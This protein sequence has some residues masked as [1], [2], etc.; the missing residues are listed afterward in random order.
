[1]KTA[2][3]SLSLAIISGLA[4]PAYAQGSETPAPAA[5]P[6]AEPSTPSPM[7]M[8]LSGFQVVV[9][10]DSDGRAVSRKTEQG[11]NGLMVFLEPSAAQ[12]ALQNQEIADARPGAIPLVNVL[13]GW[14]GPV[15][16]EGAAD[17]RTK[18]ASLSPEVGEFAAPAFFV[19][20]NDNEAQ[21]QMNGEAV[22][23]IL[24]SYDDAEDLAKRLA[25][26]GMPEE[27]V[28]VVPIEVAGVLQQLSTLESDRGYRI[29]THPD[30]VAFI[31]SIQ[32]QSAEGEAP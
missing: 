22:T 3:A 24:L 15:L 4:A 10:M 21:V 32:N 25:G 19:T 14:N 29:F 11:Q 8:A 7:Q 2:L 18:A 26:Q 30:T 12:A 17:D 9:L 23:P 31:Q 28:E 6:A 5:P 27:A 16:F 1:M 20:A 13:G